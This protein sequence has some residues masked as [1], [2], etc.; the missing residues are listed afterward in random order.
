MKNFSHPPQMTNQDEHNLTHTHTRNAHGTAAVRFSTYKPLL[1]NRELIA[2]R[3]GQ[4]RPSA[5]ASKTCLVEKTKRKH[6]NAHTT[7]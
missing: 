7:M 2:S 1:V 3:V 5:F 6:I 4:G